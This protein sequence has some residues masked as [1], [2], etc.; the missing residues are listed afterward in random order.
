M[1]S[2]TVIAE[3]VRRL[4]LEGH[5]VHINRD[6]M[7]R[8]DY[9]STLSVILAFEA[10]SPF[11]RREKRLPTAAGLSRAS[12]TPPPFLYGGG[13]LQLRMAKIPSGETGAA[14]REMVVSF[15][16]CRVKHEV[17]S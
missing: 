14:S 4:P 7:H 1:P 16:A 17:R 15:R 3:A 12:L 9:P 13:G 10:S 11:A 6:E 2:C 5:S 8:E